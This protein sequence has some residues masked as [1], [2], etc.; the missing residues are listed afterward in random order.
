MNK[1]IMDKA[2][3]EYTRGFYMSLAMGESPVLCHRNALDLVRLAGFSDE[4]EIPQLFT[5]ES[6]A[7]RGG[8]GGEY[9]SNGAA[10]GGAVE[11]SRRAEDSRAS[12]SPDELFARLRTLMQRCL[13][14]HPELHAQLKTHLSEPV[15][16][17][18]MQ[19]TAVEIIDVLA[20]ISWKS[21]PLREAVQRFA[22]IALP[23][24]IDWRGLRAARKAGEAHVRLPFRSGP[25]CEIALAGL[26]GRPAELE[27][28]D[29]CPAAVRD[30]SGSLIPLRRDE[31]QSPKTVQAA[32]AE[33]I[34][35]KAGMKRSD[36]PPDDETLIKRARE[37]IEYWR[38]EEEPSD[39]YQMYLVFD[40]AS[41]DAIES[42]VA[43]LPELW[44]VQGEPDR[45]VRLYNRLR[46]L[47]GWPKDSW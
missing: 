43:V 7:P 8:T 23:T 19:M 36:L 46:K 39:R 30:P 33:A 29:D 20:K 31:K 15:I 47:Y 5:P 2:C 3:Q 13:D 24:A 17:A 14:D 40:E 28:E 9:E 10:T 41:P 21:V 38:S 4:A 12:L 22:M 34:L 37:E 45:P 35:R 1:K 25:L 11:D 16:D 27:N 44:L 6:I 42:M 18:I 26:D 32:V